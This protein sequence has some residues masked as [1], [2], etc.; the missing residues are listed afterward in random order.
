MSKSKPPTDAGLKGAGGASES[1]RG[2]ALSASPRTA[3]AERPALEGRQVVPPSDETSRRRI[4]EDL[5]TTF[6]VEAGAGSGKTTKLVDRISAL[7]ALGKAEVGRI[8]AVTFT[9]KAAAELREKL[10]Q[11]LEKR[12]VEDP[13]PVVRERMRTAVADIGHAFI[14]TIHSFCARILRERPVESGLDPDFTEL[15]EAE[16]G[17][18]LETCWQDYLAEAHLRNDPLLARLGEIGIDAAGLEE[19]YQRLCQF[20]DIEPYAPACPKPDLAPARRK[21]RRFMAAVGKAMPSD[22][23]DDGWDKLQTSYRRAAWLLDT[24]GDGRDRDLIDILELFEKGAVTLN[25]WP[26]KKTAKAFKDGFLPDFLRDSVVPAVRGWREHVYSDCV[27][28]ARAA[29]EFAAARRSVDSTLD[30]TDLLIKARDLLR[31]NNDVR[32]FFSR[33][34]THI[35]V[36]EFQ[37]TDPVQCE[38]LFYLCGDAPDRRA[39][40]RKFKLRSGALFV[41]GDPKQSIYRFRRADIAAYNV[42]RILIEKNGG[43]VLTLSANYRSVNSIGEFVD[44]AFDHVFPAEATEKQAAFVPLATQK[45]DVAALSGVRKLV[46]EGV[47]RKNDIFEYSSGLIAS[48]VAWALDGNVHVEEYGELRP[49]TPGDILILTWQREPLIVLAAALEARQVPFDI[50]GSRGAFAVP[51]IRDT[52]KL[53]DS[54]ADPDNPVALVGVLISPLF[55]HSYQALWDYRKA[56]GSF[57]F[58]G[59]GRLEGPLAEHPVAV[60]LAKIESWWRLTL[61]RSPAA[62]IGSILERPGLARWR[63]HPRWERRWRDACCSSSR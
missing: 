56:G 34:F 41:V 10:Q 4:V 32:G 12:A 30:Y 46:V 43:E 13:D 31:D 38:I 52:L 2:R 15:E 21:L 51:E 39:D 18:F 5:D 33:R 17:G 20:R 36:D 50:T 26:D 54:L 27:A 6:L 45:K 58:L 24:Y 8:A 22:E 55:G 19:L 40:W 48:W 37:D 1:S 3:G 61:D 59:A 28:F 25:R 57:R 42:V 29:A 44:G 23:P 9:R 47:S 35:L 53:F 60:S 11:R 62:A 7:L 14:G 63:R 16:A 49:A